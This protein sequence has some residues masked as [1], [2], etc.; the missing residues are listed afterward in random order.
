MASITHHPGLLFWVIGT[1]PAVVDI[2]IVRLL[3]LSLTSALL[4]L[5]VFQFRLTTIDMRV[6][7]IR[8]VEFR[9]ALTYKHSIR[10]KG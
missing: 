2:T 7:V 6:R 10:R 8:E 5:M 1:L 9:F 3:Y 4:C